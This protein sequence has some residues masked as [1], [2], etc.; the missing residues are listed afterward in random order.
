MAKLSSIVAAV[1]LMA[2]STTTHA[3][4][5]CTGKIS[6]V[7]IDD[8]LWVHFDTGLVWMFLPDPAIPTKAERLKKLTAAATAALMAEKSVTVRFE[9][10]GV[11]CTGNQ[12][13][14]LVWGLYLNA[15]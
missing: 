9:A 11:A 13:A 2:A 7:W 6:R 3:Y 14:Q 15:T 1:F 10:D 5:E 8:S 4:T 12:T